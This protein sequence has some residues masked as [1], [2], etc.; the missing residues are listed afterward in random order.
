[1][2]IV[3]LDYGMGNTASILNM[4]RKAGGSAVISADLQA[5]KE[6]RAI[7]LPGVG[8]FDNGMNKL[9]SLGLIELL[10]NKIVV[11][12]TP[13]LGV[14]LGM[15]L[16]FDRSA[17]GELPGLGWIKGSVTRFDFSLI[18]DCSRLKIPHMGWNLIKP[19]KNSL[20]FK[21]MEDKG[22][23]YFSHSYHAV[24]AQAADVSAT[25]FHGYDFTCAVRKDN[26]FGAQ[27]HPEKS[28]RFGLM[29]FK[30][31]LRYAKC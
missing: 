8:A 21:G 25:S 16:L 12:K 27:F 24:G 31:F 6:A 5:V 14:C 15:Q 2:M 9:A 1:M 7:I 18:N 3:I 30:N 10:R 17:E 26:I 11:E 29:L 28:H 22:R 20:L 23:F 13:F 4:V 19:A